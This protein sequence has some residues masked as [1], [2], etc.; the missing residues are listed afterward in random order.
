M[1][2]RVVVHFDIGVKF[3]NYKCLVTKLKISLS[4]MYFSIQLNQI[5]TRGR[6]PCNANSGTMQLTH[7]SL[8]QCFEWDFSEWGI[9]TKNYTEALLEAI[10]TSCIRC[11]CARPGNFETEYF[12]KA[13]GC[14]GSFH[15]QKGFWMVLV[16]AC[17]LSRLSSALGRCFSFSLC[18]FCVS[19]SPG[20]WRISYTT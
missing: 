10:W 14:V 11:N 6:K 4:Q 13:V 7:T 1:M 19:I 3:G 8:F 12:G 5:G 16:L 9:N 15:L 17:S 2:W 18:Y 20:F